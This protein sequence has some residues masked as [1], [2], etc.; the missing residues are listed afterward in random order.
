MSTTPSPSLHN[1]LNIM[2]VVSVIAVSSMYLELRY[3]YSELQFSCLQKRLIQTGFDE[4]KTNSCPIACSNY[5]RN[6]AKTEQEQVYTLSEVSVK[7]KS[8]FYFPETVDSAE[9]LKS[10]NIHPSDPK[11]FKTSEMLLTSSL[12][13]TSKEFGESHVDHFGTSL[14]SPLNFV[15]LTGARLEL[16]S[17]PIFEHSRFTDETDCVDEDPIRSQTISFSPSEIDLGDVIYTEEK[18]ILKSSIKTI[19]NRDYE[20]VVST[21]TENQVKALEPTPQ[22][23]LMQPTTLPLLQTSTEPLSIETP[24]KQQLWNHQKLYTAT[25]LA[26]PE[27][28]HEILSTEESTLPDQESCEGVS[29]Q[30]IYPGLVS[31]FASNFENFDDKYYRQGDLEDEEMYSESQTQKQKVSSQSLPFPDLNEQWAAKAAD[32]KDLDG[33]SFYGSSMR[34]E[35]FDQSEFCHFENLCYNTKEKDFVFLMGDGSKIEYRS[36]AGALEQLSQFALNLS[37]VPEHNAHTFPLVFIPAKSVSVFKVAVIKEAS[38]IMSRFKPDNIMHVFH[39]DLIP[40]IHTLSQRRLLKHHGL[41]DLR[42]VM[43]D[44]FNPMENIHLYTSIFSDT[45]IWLFNPH[46]TVDFICFKDSYTGLSK[47]TLWYQY[48]FSK[49][50]GPLSNNVIHVLGNVKRGA[51]Y[52]ANILHVPCFFC[53]GGNYLVLLS[54]KD[55]RLITNEG[56]LVMRLV[57]ST[58]MK[59][60]SVS[61]ETHSIRDI[62]SIVKN[63][64]GMIGMHGSL[65]VFGIFLPP[66]SILIELFPYGVNPS[67][68]TP[69]KTFCDFPNSGIVYSSWSNLDRSKSVEHPHRPPELGGIHH[70]SQQLQTQILEQ[71]EVPEHMCCEDPSW[72]YHIYQDTEVDVEAVV[73]MTISA[74]G[75]ASSIQGRKGHGELI[76]EEKS[77]DKPEHSYKD[78]YIDGVR[79]EK[80]DYDLFYTSETQKKYFLWE[81]IKDRDIILR[82]SRVRFLSCELD[83][84]SFNEDGTRRNS[85]TFKVTWTAPWNLQL[86]GFS[87]VHYG[88][89]YQ[90]KGAASGKSVQI[91]YGRL[92]YLIQT[93]T[94]GDEYLVWVRAVTKDNIAGLDDFVSCNSSDK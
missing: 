84:E 44:M 34:C 91:N 14:N 1:L 8:D 78:N 46:V 17:L 73:A 4:S 19:T 7:A 88:I 13:K 18:L 77:R 40:L 30:G 42:L 92:E 36:V 39:D 22:I 49:P 75:Q 89:I 28:D 65:L 93:H 63:S 32:I 85:H 54:R 52:L 3:R 83:S 15:T 66:G 29:C 94:P 82:P 50:Q 11:V 12:A 58:K 21:S 24:T 35:D 80:H 64:R 90:L 20:P 62:I 2:L 81:Q 67:K 6:I 45:P 57:Q 33:I 59:V 69:F 41:S 25:N 71:T 56:A 72:L 74:L 31:N 86:L 47:A 68:Y 9:K 43:A 27:Q 76:V 10:E 79:K 51:N 55:N 61:V 5:C 16:T 87:E 70:L 48:G 38:F 23:N 53:K 37:S 26:Q 60:M